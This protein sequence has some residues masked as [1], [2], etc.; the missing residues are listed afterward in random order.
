M[1]HDRPGW[2]RSGNHSKAGVFKSGRYPGEPV[3][4]CRRLFDIHGVGFQN[5]GASA[6]GVPQGRTDQ[7]CAHTPH[8]VLAAY[9]K[10]REAP[11]WSVGG[12]RQASIAFKPGELFARPEL[13]PADGEISL[14]GEE[15][16]RRTA[17][18]D[19]A[20]VPLVRSMISQPVCA[21]EPPIH[22]P[23]PVARSCPPEQ[24]FERRPELG[25][26]GPYCHLQ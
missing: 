22:A 5:P 7:R 16:G 14:K 13:S 26:Y 23:A 10:A 19:G 20:D 12:L 9:E 17:F 6:F 15:S 4:A 2:R 25:G 3:F 1:P 8:A 18:N 21:A 11:K 24:V